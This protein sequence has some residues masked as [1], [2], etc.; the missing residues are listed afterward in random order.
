MGHGAGV[1]P[2]RVGDYGSTQV[3]AAHRGLTRTLTGRGERTRASGPVERSVSRSRIGL[4][5]KRTRIPWTPSCLTG[6]W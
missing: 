1:F 6:R 4:G 2:A 5:I 3:S